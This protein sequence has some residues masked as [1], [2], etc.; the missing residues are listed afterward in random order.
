MEIQFSLSLTGADQSSSTPSPTARSTWS[1]S[2]AAAT[3]RKRHVKCDETRPACLNCLKW[4]GYCGSYAR[5]AAD[6]P[7]SCAGAPDKA[8]TSPKPVAAASAPLLL[9]EPTFHALRFAS[10]E[11]RAYFDEWCAL[12]V[13]FLSGRLGRARLWTVTMPQLTLEERTLRYGAMAVGAMHKA[14]EVAAVG[15]ND[16]YLNAVVYYCEALRLQSKARPTEEGLRTAL[17]SSL[18]F[19]CFETQRGNVAAALKHVTHGFSML[20][21]LA[22]C[23]EM[24]PALVRI[25]PAPPALVQEILDC[26]KPLEMQSRSFLGSYRKFFFPPQPPPP[27]PPPPSD[28]PSGSPAAPPKSSPWPSP[29]PSPHAVA[30]RAPTSRS[31]RLG[32]PS[33][34]SPCS[35]ASAAGAAGAAPGDAPLSGRPSRPPGILPFTKLTPY[36]RPK[37]TRITELRDLPPAFRDMDEAHG[38]WALVQRSMVRSIPML[39]MV[40]SRLAL[41]KAASEAEVESKLATVKQNP[42]VSEFVATSRRWLRSWSDAY[43]PLFREA[44]RNSSKHSDVH[45]EA[46][47]LR[48]E[49]LLLYIYTT[50]PRFSGLGTAKGLTTQYREINRLAETLLSATPSCG[51]A[52]DSGW[53][54]PLF[55]SAFACRDAAVRADAIRILGQYPIRNA[56]RDSRVFRAIALKNEE[57]EAAVAMD[58]HEADQWLRLRRRELVFEDFGTSII[59]RSPRKNPATGQW[60]LVEEVAG[61]NVGSDGKLHWQTQPISESASIL[62]GV[63]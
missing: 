45:L 14:R 37:L 28:A 5:E 56:L 6:S 39:S 34:Q 48:V 63:C 62:S 8:R 47:N 10:V 60:D 18:L 24:A 2:R 49:Y 30:A 29:M 1:A 25:A 15:G 44:C 58:G 31:P 17:L 26:Y 3:H 32:L 11:Q 52:M 46:L 16:H 36:F 33:P 61:F 53:T 27:P 35:P 38:Y 43:E 4:R 57:V 55:V 19:I 54:W 40:T 23:T 21:E 50:I 42:D 41:T 9:T 20:N 51:F 22:A 59:Y 12:S 13:N 7:A